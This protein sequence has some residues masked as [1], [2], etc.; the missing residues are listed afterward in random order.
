MLT[1]IIELETGL[2]CEAIDETGDTV[3]VFAP[4]P[5]EDDPEI[6]LYIQQAGKKLLLTD[7]A[8]VYLHHGT[9]EE[10]TNRIA[11]VVRSFGLEFTNAAI[12]LHCELDSLGP[13]VERFLSVM[14]ALAAQEQ[15]FNRMWAK[16][17]TEPTAL[18]A[19]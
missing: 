5:F 18:A 10:A 1:D 12:E 16:S 2:S 13:A 11:E 8:E 14:S 7:D 6:F 3:A 4:R 15:D 9:C 17:R 19:K